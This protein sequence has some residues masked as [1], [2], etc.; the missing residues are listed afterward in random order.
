MYR[1]NTL[2][3]QFLWSSALVRMDRTDTD[4]QVGMSKKQNAISPFS[5]TVIV[6]TFGFLFNFTTFEANA[7]IDLPGVQYIKH[8]QTH[9]L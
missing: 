4:T 9:R 8:H 6:V 5:Y 1:L 7:T 3:S 2:P